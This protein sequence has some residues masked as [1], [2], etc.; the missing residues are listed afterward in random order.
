MFRY[1]WTIL[2][3]S[4][5]STILLGEMLLCINGSAQEKPQ[6]PASGTVPGP[7]GTARGNLRFAAAV[8]HRCKPFDNR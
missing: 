5:V 7:R 3:V 4:F 2:I 8:N 6:E 1:S